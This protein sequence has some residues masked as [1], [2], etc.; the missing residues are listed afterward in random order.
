MTDRMWRS[1]S[2]VALAASLAIGMTGCGKAS[3]T[4]RSPAYVVVQG[5]EAASGAEPGKFGTE[6]FSDVETIVKKQVDGEE[7]GVPTIFADPGRVSLT[8]S[9]KDIGQPGNPTAPTTNNA[10]TLTRYRV[11][12]RRTDGRG[13]PGVDVPYGFEGAST[14][15]VNGGSATTMGFTLVRVQAKEEAPLRGMV[16]GGASIV[17]T[18]IADITFYGKDQ[19]GNDV[20]ATG[21]IAVHFADFGDPD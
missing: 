14:A 6:L 20:E 4:G 9:L 1:T 8:L 15:T 10:V 2:A 11:T 13:T 18:A 21:S 17:F 3:R 16:Q 5:I 7:V 19:V 12:F